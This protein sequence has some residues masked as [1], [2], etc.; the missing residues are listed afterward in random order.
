MDVG[1]RLHREPFLTHMLRIHRA[2]FRSGRVI[3]EN[4]DQNQ[5]EVPIEQSEDSKGYGHDAPDA[6][7]ER[8]GLQPSE[9]RRHEGA[10]D[11]TAIHRKR[12][13]QVEQAQHQVN[14][15]QVDEKLSKTTGGG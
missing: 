6:R 15:E 9:P 2:V 3:D 5:N 11:A 4:R 10:E 14:D 7:G 1:L 8:R 12:R 13:E